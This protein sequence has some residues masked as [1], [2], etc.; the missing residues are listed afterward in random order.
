MRREREKRV[1]ERKREERNKIFTMKTKGKR[2][3]KRREEKERE[4]T[5]CAGVRFRSRRVWRLS[6]G[7]QDN[8][9]DTGFG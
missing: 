8:N 7:I 2:D 6:I 9:S 3:L 5:V 4:L 1:R